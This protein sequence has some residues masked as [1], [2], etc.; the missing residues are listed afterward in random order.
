MDHG[1][2]TEPLDALARDSAMLDAPG[3][4]EDDVLETVAETVPIAEVIPSCVVVASGEA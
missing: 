3:M 1:L 4:T 2:R